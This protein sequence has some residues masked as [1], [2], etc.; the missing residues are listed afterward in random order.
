MCIVY[1]FNQVGIFI[2][3]QFFISFA[4]NYYSL[5]G[6][7]ENIS[8]SLYLGRVVGCGLGVKGMDFTY[9]GSEI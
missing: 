8:D 3:L 9:E 2:S 1:G 6:H 4:S 5:A 7:K